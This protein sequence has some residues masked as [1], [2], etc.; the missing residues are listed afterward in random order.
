M[1]FD[2]GLLVVTVIRDTWQNIV[3]G[4]EIV[5]RRLIVSD[6]EIVLRCMIVSDTEIVLRCRI[7]SDT[8]TVSRSMIVSDTEI[9]LTLPDANFSPVPCH[10]A[11]L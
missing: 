10:G 5:L 8:E 9:V 3:L 7:V 4:T 2:T 1:F 11:C 6:T